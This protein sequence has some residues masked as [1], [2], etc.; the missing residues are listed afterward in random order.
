MT[1]SEGALA[2]AP[3]GA[4]AAIPPYIIQKF[5]EVRALM[6]KGASIDPLP[7]AF[8]GRLYVEL[9]YDEECPVAMQYALDGVKLWVINWQR[10]RRNSLPASGV[11]CAREGCSGK[12][13][14]MRYG[15][16]SGGGGIRQIVRVD[17]RACLNGYCLPRHRMLF[18]FTDIASH[19]IECYLTKR[20]QCCG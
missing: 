1:T 9:R 8:D 2:V 20:T 19:V 6:G 7:D 16:E 12:T 5:H 3:G 18:S 4:R 14:A 10:Q 13:C 11:P 17:G 15:C